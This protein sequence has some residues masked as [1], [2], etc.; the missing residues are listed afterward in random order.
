VSATIEW[1]HPNISSA[2]TSLP[3]ANCPVVVRTGAQRVQ[4]RFTVTV[5]A[6]HLRDYAISVAGCGPGATP[7]LITDGRDGLPVQSAT[8]QSHWHMN[9]NDNSA[10]VVLHYEL[11]AGAPAGCYQFS[12]VARSRTFDPRTTVALAPSQSPENFWNLAEQAPIY[13][14]P[15]WSVAVQ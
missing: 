4:F 1:R 8:A 15:L 6:T 5:S 13:V 2:F 10:T 14:A 7:Q 9:A 3:L 12:V 11:A